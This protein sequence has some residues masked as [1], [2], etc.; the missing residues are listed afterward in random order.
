MLRYPHNPQSRDGRKEHS[1]K[2]RQLGADYSAW[3]QA[4]RSAYALAAWPF[5]EKKR[6][7]ASL[8]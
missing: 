6:H 4:A 5:E 8:V 1:M 2:H 7:R 3:P